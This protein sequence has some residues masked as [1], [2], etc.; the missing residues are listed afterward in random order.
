MAPPAQLINPSTL[1]SVLA[2]GT[3]YQLF[4]V[5]GLLEGFMAV[6]PSS[7]HVFCGLGEGLWPF[8]PG[9]PVGGTVGGWGTTSCLV[10]L[11]P[12]WELCFLAQSQ[13]RTSKTSMRSWFSARK[14]WTAPS[15]LGL[16]CCS[17]WRSASILDSCSWVRVKWSVNGQIGE[18]AAVMWALY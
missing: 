15:R 16:S 4:T 13:I 6:C 12:K 14:Q 5:T 2:I 18:A 10:L 3:V 7:V 17:K 11:L 9:S 1:N 8:P